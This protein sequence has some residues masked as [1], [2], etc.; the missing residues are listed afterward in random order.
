VK[1]YTCPVCD[2]TLSN[3][4]YEKA[5]GIVEERYRLLETD[6]TVALRKLF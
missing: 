3:T 5:L 1:K 6:R 2:T 4:A